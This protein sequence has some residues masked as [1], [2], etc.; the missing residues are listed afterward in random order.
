MEEQIQVEGD[1]VPL[2]DCE[3][4]DKSITTSTPVGKILCIKPVNK[5]AIKNILTRA[6]G[7]SSTLSIVD[8]AENC[9]MF[10]FSE[11]ELPKKI[12]EDSP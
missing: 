2:E 12:M 9:F 5:G 11:D 4:S 1:I 6:W 3:E 10:N 8:L 7:N